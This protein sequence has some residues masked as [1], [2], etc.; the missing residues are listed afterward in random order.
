MQSMFWVRS[1]RALPPPS[2]LSWA[3]PVHCR[4]RRHHPTP[5]RLPDRTSPRVSYDALPST[6]QYASAF[7]QSL[8]FDTSKV[9]TTRYMF[10]VRSARALPPKS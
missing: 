1:V 5:S 9:T 10:Y 7:N 3:F 8:S 2:L 6:R 4:L